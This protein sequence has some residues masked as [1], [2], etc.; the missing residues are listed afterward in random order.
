MIR[1]RI[2]FNIIELFLR[3]WQQ[4]QFPLAT[5]FLDPNVDTIF[6]ILIPGHHH[7]LK[8]Q[9]SINF[10]SGSVDQTVSFVT[11]FLVD[12]FFTT[13]GHD[14]GAFLCG[15]DGSGAFGSSDS[16]GEFGIDRLIEEILVRMDHDCHNMASL[17]ELKTSGFVDF[18]LQQFESG[19]F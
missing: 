19:R 14:K 5:V 15:F 3:D 10:N 13:T 17:T 8:V 7:W 6:I 4:H 18:H 1:F 12:S 16:I 11:E 2:E 9:D